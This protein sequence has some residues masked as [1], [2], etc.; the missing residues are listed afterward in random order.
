MAKYSF[1]FKMQVVNDYLNGNGGYRYLA[2]KYGIP[3]YSTVRKWVNAYNTLGAEGL[4]RSRQKEVYSFEFK[5]HAVELY[6]S[7]EVSYQELANTLQLN[8]LSLLVRWVN[9]FRAVGPDA[10][11]PHKKGRRSTVKN[12]KKKKAVKSEKLDTET[13][14]YIKELEDELLRARIENAYLKELRRLR[15]AEEA[16]LKEKR[17]SSTVSEDHSN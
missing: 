14:A 3:Q 15:L 2:Q 7:S 16:L 6:L 5:L 11:R 1:E 4:K 12:D 8:N 9:D 10:L 13:A 17:E